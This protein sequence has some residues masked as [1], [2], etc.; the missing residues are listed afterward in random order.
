MNIYA[1]INPD[2]FRIIPAFAFPCNVII[3]VRELP[4]TSACDLQL[5]YISS[6][7]EMKYMYQGLI[8]ELGKQHPYCLD[9]AAKKMNKAVPQNSLKIDLKQ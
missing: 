6:M 4:E 3:H 5:A 7:K 9:H 2:Q 8:V 1:S